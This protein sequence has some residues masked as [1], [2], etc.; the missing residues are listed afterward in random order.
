MFPGDQN[1]GTVPFLDRIDMIFRIWRITRH[2]SSRLHLMEGASMILAEVEE[3]KPRLTNHR[4]KIL[5]ILKI[6]SI[7]LILS[8]KEAG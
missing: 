1:V 4:R 2:D 5:K 8:K 3:S 6:M 7:L